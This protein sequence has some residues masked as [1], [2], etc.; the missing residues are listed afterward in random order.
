MLVLSISSILLFLLSHFPAF[1]A[2]SVKE[3]CPS[4][5]H[6]SCASGKADTI[7][8]CAARCSPC[9]GWPPCRPVPGCARSPR[10]AATPWW[11]YSAQRHRSSKGEREMEWVEEGS[12]VYLHANC[13]NFA[14]CGV[15]TWQHINKCTAAT[16]SPALSPLQKGDW[17][18]D[19]PPLI[20]LQCNKKNKL[21]LIVAVARHLHHRHL[22]WYLM[23]CL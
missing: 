15:I 16:C 20:A 11:Q 12:W 5:S 1:L 21:N 9:P 10:N 8:W 18:P 6:H 19:V 23:V 13:V 2:C 14:L 22:T 4:R 17:P 7:H 3:S